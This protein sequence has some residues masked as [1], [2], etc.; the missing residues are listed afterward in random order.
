M[1]VTVTLNPS[2]DRTLRIEHLRPG[3][4]HRALETSTD[5][6]GKGVNVARALAAHGAAVLTVLPVGATTGAAVVD[7]LTESA[8]PHVAVPVE[9]RTRVNVSLAEL[10]GTT[11]KI[12]EPGQPLS[13]REMAAVTDAV[14][15]RVRPGDWVVTAGSLAPGQNPEVYAALGQAAQNAGARWALDTSGEALLASLNAGPDL[16]KPNR[17]ELEEVLTGPADTLGDVVE[18]CRALVGGG[19]L[20]V[21]CSLGADGAVLVDRDGAWHGTGPRVQ[22]ANTV[23]AGDALLAGYLYGITRGAEPPEALRHG[24]AWATAA[25]AT[26]GTGV[27]TPTR[28]QLDKVH[29]A[30][31]RESASFLLE[32][33]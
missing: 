6:G 31:A 20:S 7:L 5:P 3:A 4:V 10:D 22:V 17:D 25:V 1:I 30:E 9:G 2:L 27:P 18:R 12:N 16:V 28:V 19:P 23:G 13:A 33:A 26:R 8:V 21:V 32:N 15:S 11:T 29:I 14:I 24:V